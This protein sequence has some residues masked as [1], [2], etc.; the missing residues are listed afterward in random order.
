F[1]KNFLSLRNTPIRREQ[2]RP[3]ST[4]VGSLGRQYSGQRLMWHSSA[5]AP[6][7]VSPICAQPQRLPKVEKLS[8][9]FVPWLFR[10]RRG[11]RSLPSKKDCTRFSRTPDSNGVTRAARC[12]WE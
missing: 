4:W 10:V 5:L 1:P 8:P 7:H 3:T 12:A 9:A 2:G 6:I 11:L